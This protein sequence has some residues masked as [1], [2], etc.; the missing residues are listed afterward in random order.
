MRQCH[1]FST[2]VHRM[3]FERALLHSWGC[4]PHVGILPHPWGVSA[5]CTAVV[6]IA[7]IYWDTDGPRGHGNAE[8]YPHFT[9]GLAP[10]IGSIEC[11]GWCSYYWWQFNAMQF[12]IKRIEYSLRLENHWTRRQ[13]RKMTTK[14]WNSDLMKKVESLGCGFVKI[15]ILKISP[16]CIFYSKICGQNFPN[17]NFNLTFFS[18]QILLPGLFYIKF[19]FPG[20]FNEFKWK[21]YYRIFPKQ[22]LLTGFFRNKFSCLEFFNKG[23]KKI[24]LQDFLVNDSLKGFSISKSYQEKQMFLI[25]KFYS[26][27]FNDYEIIEK[28]I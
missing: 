20:M 14:S 6:V 1:C 17:K 11:S 3:S 12:T 4:C 5:S 16:I 28:F 2:N 24:W 13:S 8:M 22:I 18:K 23:Q 25:N 15:F 26:S 7:A 9:E 10:A 19:S 27:L 21:S